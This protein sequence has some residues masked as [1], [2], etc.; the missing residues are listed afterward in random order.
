MNLKPRESRA[1]LAG[2]HPAIVRPHDGKCP[3][4]VGEE[5]VLRTQKTIAGPISQVSITITAKHRKSPTSWEA[6][7]SVKD[8]RGL[9]LAKGQGYTRSAGDSIDWE[10]PVDDEDTLREYAATGRQKSALLGTEHRVAAQAKRD[11]QRLEKARS[12]SQEKTVRTLE[13]VKRAA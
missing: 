13:R 8:D 5:I 3:F 12:A 11:E 2:G 7:Y 1:I 4:E 9:Y 6:I 10:A